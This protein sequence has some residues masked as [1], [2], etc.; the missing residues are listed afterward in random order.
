MKTEN[1]KFLSSL[2]SLEG[3]T[4][5]LTGAAGYFGKVF[6]DTLV[7]SGAKVILFAKD[8]KG[9]KFY[10][11]LI[12]KYGRE[13]IFYYNVNLYN[14][15]EYKKCLLD[16]TNSQRTIDILVNNAFDFSKSTAFNDPSGKFE[17]ISKEQWMNTFEAGVYWHALA[18]QVVA[19]KMKESR[20]GSIINV[21]SMYG[22]V[23]P[24]PELYEGVEVF[25]PPSYSSAKAAILALTRYA[26]SFYGQYNIRCNCLIP[27]S[28]PNN[29]PDAYNAPKN[30]NFIN[31]LNKKTV[32]NRTGRVEEL[33]G[34]LIYLASDS[35][36]YMTGQ[37]I[38][39]DGGW[40]IK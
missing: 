6:A 22:L 36:S 32:L 21:S 7:M 30:E 18:I 20:F 40:T 37:T 23:A 15:A 17:N 1:N 28:F 34:A 31:K 11:E 8:E 38:V 16:A 24:D 4:A 27:G 29:D 14:T 35:S 10:N 5:I 26:A 9:E 3:K 25:N 39:V 12:D 13:N 2:F 19:E 33:R